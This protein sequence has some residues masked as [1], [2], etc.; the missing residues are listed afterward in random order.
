MHPMLTIATRAAR[1]AGTLIARAFDR[2]DQVEIQYKSHNQI[3]TNVDKQAEQEII[4]TLRKSY[5]D[6]TFIGEE[7]GENKGDGEYTWFIDPIDGTTNFIHGLAYFCVSIAACKDNKIEHA[8]IYD[9]IR[10][11]LFTAS[12]GNGA[13]HNEKRMRI[14]TRQHLDGALIGFST[15]VFSHPKYPQMVRTFTHRHL[16]A[17]A[18]D[19]AYVAAGFLDGCI[20]YNL[21]SWDMMAGALLVR[22]AGGLVGDDK[23]NEDYLSR[24][25]IIAGNPKLFAH[26][27]RQLQITS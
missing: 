12:R 21:K 25:N 18:L 9:P 5:P 2:L 3:V 26:I 10:N 24:G 6:H 17:A 7:S 20:E 19:L 23:G 27:V 15:Q 16:G 11:D 1:N 22:E 13:Q 8:V 14:S 4:N